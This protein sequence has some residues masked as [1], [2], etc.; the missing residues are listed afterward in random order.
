MSGNHMKVKIPY[1]YNRYETIFKDS[2]DIY[3]TSSDLKEGDNI[4]IEL[5]CTTM[6]DINNTC[7]LVWKTNLIKKM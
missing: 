6:W 5:N 1:R 2:Q 3:I 7:G 4:E